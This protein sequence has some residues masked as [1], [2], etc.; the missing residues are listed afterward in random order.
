LA[1]LWTS[2][3]SAA[4]ATAVPAFANSRASTGPRPP[5]PPMI[6]TR[7]P[8]MSK[9][10]KGLAPRPD[11]GEAATALGPRPLEAPARCGLH[12][13]LVPDRAVRHDPDVQ[14][15]EPGQS[16]E[17]ALDLAREDPGV[18]APGK[19]RQQADRHGIFGHVDRLDDPHREQ[20]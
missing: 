20:A 16:A 5:Q 14:P 15:S 10:T 1:T 8:V 19:R 3:T 17:L 4:I 2:G 12:P 13:V 18:E 9:L 6:S 11:L 7:L